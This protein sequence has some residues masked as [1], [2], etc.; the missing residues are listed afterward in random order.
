ML[1]E[2]VNSFDQQRSKEK[3]DYMEISCF[4]VAGT[5]FETSY[6]AGLLWAMVMS[7]SWNVAVIIPMD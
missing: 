2:N 6:L 5:H 4:Q 1:L 3:A 7:S